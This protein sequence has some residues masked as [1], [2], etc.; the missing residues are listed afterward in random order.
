[1]LYSVYSTLDVVLE[2]TKIVLYAMSI[3]SKFAKVYTWLTHIKEILKKSS[4]IIQLV[5]WTHQFWLCYITLVYMYI[6]MIQMHISKKTRIWFI[7]VLLIQLLISCWF[8]LVST[9]LVKLNKSLKISL[10]MKSFLSICRK[11]KLL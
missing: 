3:T 8:W 6:L 2:R 7:F 10:S 11:L 9:W 5:N 4:Q 1:M